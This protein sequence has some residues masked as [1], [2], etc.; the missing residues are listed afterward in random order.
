M[1]QKPTSSSPVSDQPPE[2]PLDS[3][4]SGAEVGDY[5]DDSPCLFGEQREVT[6]LFADLRKSTDLAAALSHEEMCEL[7]GHVMDCLTAEVLAQAGTVIDYFGDGLAAMWNAPHE[8]PD[9]AE[10]ACRAAMGMLEAIPQVASDW[11]PLLESNRLRLGAGIH[12]GIVQ[13]GNAGSRRR[14]KYGPRGAN[15]HVASRVEA[16]TKHIGVPLVLTAATASQLPFCMGTFRLCRAELPGVSDSVDLFGLC[17]AQAQ[18]ELAATREVYRRALGHFEKGELHIA[19]ELL[20]PLPLVDNP[21]VRFLSD[22]IQR[23]LGKQL[24]RRSTDAA[25]ARPPCVI[26]LGE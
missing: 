19:A 10:R 1:S 17:P 18:D 11:S 13:L 20:G 21:P 7:L 26:R 6:L 9:H 3:E 25:A 5:A 15:V 22:A 14:A 4:K 24:G 2:L 23:Q 8:Q 16:T 12:T